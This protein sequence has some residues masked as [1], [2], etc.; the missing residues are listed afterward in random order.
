MKAVFTL[1]T[2]ILFLP[3]LLCGQGDT[4]LQTFVHNDSLRSYYLYVPE[5]YDGSE[6]WPLVLNYHGF[7][8]T[9]TNQMD[10]SQMN[11]VADT[12]HFLVA[13]PQ[14]LSIANPAFGFIAPG[15][16]IDGT[17]SDNDDFGFT[18][19]LIDHI[20][21][22]YSVDR[23]RVH[24]T[25]WSLGAIMSYTLSCEMPE[26]IASIGAVSGRL[27]DFQIA[28]CDPGRPYSTLLIY[29]TDDPID[30]YEGDGF[31]FSAVPNTPA[32]YA[33]F[34]NCSTDS[35][36]TELPDV[37]TADSSTVTLIEY[38][39]CD[40]G[41]EV[42]FYRINGGGHA[43]PGG[44]DVFPDLNLGQ[45][46]LDIKASSEI[47]NFFQRNPHP[48]PAGQVLER[49]FVHNDSLRSYLLYVPAD[50]DGTEEWPLVL[51]MHG[52]AL[53]AGFQMDFS[54]M[55][56]VADTAHF[57]IA[58]PQGT[59]I[60]STVPNIPP[61][62]L[63][64][65]VSLESDTVFVSPG[66]VDD[67]GFIEAVID[68]IQAGYQ[69]ASD[70]IYATGF[71]NGAM[72]S[73]LLGLKLKDRIAAVAA[74]GATLPRS[75]LA[76]QEERVSKPVL[77]IHGTADSIA[78]YGDEDPFLASVEEIMTFWSDQ[79][80]CEA[81]PTTTPLP[82]LTTADGSTLE[83]QEWQ[84]CEAE[85]LHLKVIDGGHQWPGGNNLLP[86][87]GNF[88]LDINAS[89]EIWN[90]FN[91]NPLRKV[92]T[93]TEQVADAWFDRHVRLYP[94]PFR[95][96]LTLEL[97]LPESLPLQLTLFNALGQPVSSPM[98]YDLGQ[99]RHRVQW[100]AGDR[101]LPA[102]HYYLRLQAGNKVA[103]RALVYQPE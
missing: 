87:L 78:A 41:T 56:P 30:S 2:P 33:D 72:M 65:N 11:P 95:D 50:Y 32:F 43:W 8:N 64:W 70:R 55:N 22:A 20:D 93:S 45:L 100:D 82:D 101:A 71:S 16:N 79:N 37:M 3:A 73:H 68:S 39:N 97:D 66:F 35:V 83:W 19:Q 60:T 86:F 90:F 29:G 47:W 94:N 67:V 51:N 103:M 13:Y 28:N 14:G 25:G 53:N 102:G 40:A 63:G 74:V 84:S 89:S 24:A 18:S 92:S 85:V 1:L 77:H 23:A 76:A 99:G 12:A 21:A 4:L 81:E 98:Q 91:R 80:V 6:E 69:V 48:S 58:Y 10:I 46:N 75:Q 96:E 27:I 15:W 52:Y 31:F 36:V 54:N 62:G 38:E 88:N 44:T 7:T 61:Q 57:L 59:L 42:L 5:A 26:Q 34:N 9:A 49:S 17:L